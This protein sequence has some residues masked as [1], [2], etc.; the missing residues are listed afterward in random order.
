MCIRDRRKIEEWFKMQTDFVFYSSSIL[1]AYDGG[2]KTEAEMLKGVKVV[3]VDFAH[4]FPEQHQIDTNYLHG[5]RRV[6]QLFEEISS[7]GKALSEVYENQRRT[8]IFHSY[9]STGTLG[10][11]KWTRENGEACLPPTNLSTWQIVKGKGVDKN[12]WEY[13]TFWKGGFGNKSTG[14]CFVR[15]RKWTRNVRKS[16]SH[17]LGNGPTAAGLLGMAAK[18][19]K[20]S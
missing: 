6:I 15:R 12:G 4:T 1:F 10:R 9:K 18:G 11:A 14:G 16:S 8:T 5:L 3:I 17:E 7:E 13:A 19:T 20:K 2:A